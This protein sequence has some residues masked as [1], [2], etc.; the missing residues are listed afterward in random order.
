MHIVYSAISTFSEDIAKIVCNIENLLISHSYS[1]DAEKHNQQI[2]RH[3]STDS[4]IFYLDDTC[5]SYF[6]PLKIAYWLWCENLLPDEYA[7]I[8]RFGENDCKSM[9][10]TFIIWLDEDVKLDVSY[11]THDMVRQ[12]N[13]CVQWLATVLCL[14]FAQNKKITNELRI[15]AVIATDTWRCKND[16]FWGW[17]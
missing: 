2:N 4:A 16:S 17:I 9:W 14:R 8:L 12:A 7:L 3:N 5:L 11:F 13:G 10:F 6:E 1:V 15:T